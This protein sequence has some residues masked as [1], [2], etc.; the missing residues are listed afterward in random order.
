MAEQNISQ[1]IAHLSPEKRAS[2]FELLKKQQAQRRKSITIPRRESNGNTFALS[3]AQQRLWFLDQ[4]ESDHAL[5]NVPEAFW[6][7]GPLHIDIL[8]Q[9]LDSI[10]L[11]HEILRTTFPSIDGAPVQQIS[12]HGT[13]PLL[14]IAV[15]SHPEQNRDQVAYQMAMEEAQRSFDL[16]QGPLMRAVVYHLDAQKHLLLVVFH[17]IVV[18]G[19]S[20]RLFMSEL[21]SFYEA[22]CAQMPAPLPDL[23][24]QYLDF[25]LWQRD[26]LQGAER[27][28]Q[29][30]YWCERLEGVPML[31]LPLDHPRPALQTHTG[32]VKSLTI[33][34]EQTEALHR[35]SRQENCS[36]FM[37]LL[38]AFQFVL[39]SY[40]GQDDIPVGTLIA[41]RN[42]RQIEELI[43]FFVNTLVLRTHLDYE[44]SFREL[45]RQVRE[46]TLEAY[47]YQDIPFEML[48][49]EL[50][51]ER[52]LSVSPLFQVLFGL[53]TTTLSPMQT[54]GLTLHPQD[55][56]LGKAKVDLALEAVE[57]E[58]GIR[59]DF[60]YNTDLFEATTIARL[61]QHFQHLIQTVL[62]EPDQPL[63]ALSILTEVERR[64]I[65]E[66]WNETYVEYPADLCLQE[67]FE[68]Q[69]SLT[70]EQD[71]LLFQE[72]RLTY[73]E[74]NERANQL[75]HYLRASGVRENMLV[76]LCLERSPQMVVG[77]LAILKAGGAYV[78]LDPEYPAERLTFVV[79]DAQ[80]SVLLTQQHL[81]EK[82]AGQDVQMVCIDTLEQEVA[83]YPVSNPGQTTDAQ[84]RAYVLYTSGST[85]KPKGTQI[86]HTSVVNFLHAMYQHLPMGGQDRLLAVTTI[87]FDIAG[88]EI[89]LPLMVGATIVLAP[90]SVAMNGQKLRDLLASSA[91]TYMQA[92]PSTW[93]M[94][95]E[96]G[97]VGEPDLTILCGGESLSR[98]LANQLLDRCA[99]LW[100]VYGPTEATIWSTLTHLTS[101]ET[102]ITIGRPLANTQIYLLD[103]YLRPVPVNV[104][105]ELYIGGIGLSTGYLNRPDLTAERFIQHP[106]DP[107]PASR[108]YRTGDV[109]RYKA[110]GTIEFLGRLDHQVKIR[111][112]R[113]EL[114]EIETVLAEHPAVQDVVVL[115]K[116]REV[117]GKRLVAYLVCAAGQ[118]PSIQ[119]LRN[120][121][122][123]RLPE[124]MLPANY[125]FLPEFPLTPNGKIDRAS[126]P[127]VD[128]NRSGLNTDFVAPRNLKEEVLA[129]IWSQILGIDQVGIHDNFFELGGDSLLAVR[130][131]ARVNQAGY[132]LSVQ[133]IFQHQTIAE[134]TTVLGTS[135]ILAEQGPV[136][137]VTHFSPVQH[138][139]LGLQTPNRHYHGITV[140][141]EFVAPPKLEALRETLQFILQYHDALRLR[142]VQVDGAWQQIIDAPGREISLEQL[143]LSQV[144]EDQLDDVFQRAV[145]TFQTSFDLAKGP[146]FKAMA[147]DFGTRRPQ[148]L[149]LACHYIPADLETWHILMT[150]IDWAYQQALGGQ[151]IAFPPK[152]TAFQQFT[153]RLSAFAQSEEVAQE[154]TYWLSEARRQVPPLPLDF[155]GQHN[156]V[157]SRG[158]VP[159]EL[160][161][162]ETQILYR[163]VLKAVNIQIDSV[164]LA[165]MVDAFEAWTGTRLLLVNA[166]G[167]GRGNLFPDIDLSRTVGWISTLFPMLVDLA[168]V[169]SIDEE[170]RAV[171]AQLRSVPRQ[172][173]G[174]GLLRYLK[175]DRALVQQ[176]K[177]FPQAQVFFNFTGVRSY[178]FEQFRF[179]RPFGGFQND[180]QADRPYLIALE[181]GT[182][183]GQLRLKW[184]YSSNIHRRETVEQLAQ[185]TMERLQA[186][187]RHY[188]KS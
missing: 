164:L 159:C 135:N 13:F 96:A 133:Q 110:D 115:A 153:E 42:H 6:L 122:K 23:S 101:R 103:A 170:L 127:E 54:G 169:C 72:E 105:A 173:V 177:D 91:I 47:E 15:S 7:Q 18:D 176:F 107:E 166:L 14:S 98:D 114:G 49:D 116:E 136:T 9:A 65:V 171:N 185:R 46:V 142:L 48:V 137:G 78:P 131:V 43:G 175:E 19:W 154:Q 66:E 120:Y 129:T 73:R 83:R 99:A 152:T 12:A 10:V 22:Y 97:W 53:Q 188:T 45:M 57:N 8:Q 112:Y 184:E 20:M 64:Q 56:P 44:H 178:E 146:L 151:G 162:E 39:S 92:T 174:Y 77:L 87:A 68:K 156:T 113:I 183:E 59:C 88:L 108:I 74:L 104:S 148:S 134:L 125:Q 89:Y 147:V 32:D 37:T 52:N 34:K 121:L 16:T 100:N 109:A 36:L 26:W 51:P 28:E 75:A 5:Y 157:I 150:D 163:D 35:L 161:K 102:P 29:L 27:Q 38:A 40:A 67:L 158:V 139:F 140:Q 11:R 33:S 84:Q 62:A 126:L 95:I 124:Y 1:Q 81:C 4:F 71:A 138:W 61:L 141:L 2:L 118:E 86:R 165:A 17:H 21:A 69:A 128:Q 31:Q 76:G 132:A 117:D 123:E 119:D 58:Q 93:R 187:V 172:G 94:L 80:L 79:Q 181:C 143:D 30:R 3:F 182:I 167:H 106:F 70:P 144:P 55:I 180:L 130:V 90:R 149:V 85:G 179:V 25:A 186:I 145:V 24:L 111:G 82:F 63:H 50:Q 60:I 41:N 155:P 160:S 168:G